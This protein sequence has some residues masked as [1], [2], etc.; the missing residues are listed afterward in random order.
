VIWKLEKEVSAKND[1]RKRMKI[2]IISLDVEYF[3]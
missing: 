3:E 2:S 1:K